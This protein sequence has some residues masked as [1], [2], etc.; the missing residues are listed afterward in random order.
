MSKKGFYIVGQEEPQSYNDIPIFATTDINLKD[1]YSR[2]YLMD[3][4]KIEFP[5]CD[6]IRYDRNGNPNCSLHKGKLQE[7]Y[8]LSDVIFF[9]YDDS[10]PQTI[11]KYHI[12]NDG[13]SF[14]NRKPII[15]KKIVKTKGY[16]T[17]KNCLRYEK[18]ARERE[19]EEAIKEGKWE[20]DGTFYEIKELDVPPFKAG[21]VKDLK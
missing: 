18:V 11:S 5:I 16:I 20:K 15:G 2:L 6:C 13:E 7:F 21:K 8:A 3:L 9:A 4:D 14:C 17:C 10:R 19:M 12:D 1:D